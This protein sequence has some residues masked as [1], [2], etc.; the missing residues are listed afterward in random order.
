LQFSHLFNLRVKKIVFLVPYP[1]G[2]SPSQR[3]RFE[4]YRT[5]LEQSNFE[6]VYLSFFSKHAW[7]LINRKKKS[8]LLTIYLL[9]GFFR[10]F[11]HVLRAATGFR[12][13]IH[14]EITPIGPPVFEWIVA[15]IFR[16]RIIYDFDDAIWLTDN[17]EEG[18]L[19]RMLKWRSKVFD[20]C[21]WSFKV[22]CG[23][24]YLMSS[25]SAVNSNVVCVPTTIDTLNVHNPERYP[26]RKDPESVII[27]WTGSHS[28]I[29]YLEQV[30]PVLRSIENIFPHVG[31]VFIANE[32]PELGLSRA[33]FIPWASATEIDDLLTIDI[34]IMPLPDDDWTKGKCGFKALQY[35]A[36]ETPCVVSPVGVNAVMITHGEEGFLANT[37]EEWYRFLSLLITDR[38]LRSRMGKKGRSK[39]V[40]HYSVLSNTRVFLSLFE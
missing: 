11:F 33:Q 40:D 10:R 6:V 8:G 36:L 34:G 2:E 3:F 21:R 29:K 13:F 26:R 7:K 28:T 35:M 16:K 20:I 31:F 5:I 39:V 1:E 4:Q 17:S 22:S 14:R 32:R 23:N 38:A 12:V 37:E 18:W 27:G 19:L 30:A 9:T 24:H 25:A 15:K